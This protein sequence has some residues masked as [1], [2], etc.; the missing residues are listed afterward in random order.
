MD[1]FWVAREK[2]NIDL[3]EEEN[4]QNLPSFIFLAADEKQTWT[5]TSSWKR[6]TPPSAKD[7]NNNINNDDNNVTNDDNN[8]NND[9][10]NVNNDDNN[11]NNDNN[12]VNND[13]NNVNNDDNNVTLDDD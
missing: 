11:V 12:N 2:R 9:D 5:T 4:C 7:H 10:N 13:D 3:F 8:V 6:P 1:L